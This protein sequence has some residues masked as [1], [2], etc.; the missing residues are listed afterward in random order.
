MPLTGTGLARDCIS[1]V[2]PRQKVTALLH[3]RDALLHDISHGPYS[4]TFESVQKLRGIAKRHEQWTAELIRNPAGAILPLLNAHWAYGTFTEAVAELL[5][6]EDPVDIY[7]AVVSSSFDADR[8]D[9]LRRDRLMTGTGAGAIDFDWLMEQLRVAEVEIEAAESSGE[10]KPDPVLSFCL[11]PKALPAAEQFLLS[12]Y[13]LYEQVYLHKTTRCVEHM[14]AKLLGRIAELAGL[15]STRSAIG[16]DQ[17]HPL[18]RFFRKDGAT[19]ANFLTLDDV[20]VGGAIERMTQATDRAIADLARRLRDRKL[21]K[22]L[23]LRAFGSDEGSQRKK[24]RRIDTC[25]ASELENGSVIP[26]KSAAV[27]IY[28]RIGG[29]DDKMHKKIHIL[30]GTRPR[31]I[32]S[33]SAIVGGLAEGKQFTRYYFESGADRDKARKL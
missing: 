18:I 14:I 25:F 12:R 21:Y 16:L 11:D 22:T 24:A 28:T 23:D 30:D 1:E 20:V 29:D 19:V 26:D 32:T 5:E 17:Q 2:I 7:H 27:S 15:R 31:E 13:T 3:C 4:H 10:N 9:Y 33:L 6:A 8:L